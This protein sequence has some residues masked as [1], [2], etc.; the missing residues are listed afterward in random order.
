MQLAGEEEAI[1]RRYVALVAL[2]ASPVLSRPGFAHCDTTRGPV[3]TAAGAALEA[4]DPNLVLHWV[5]PD[6]EAAVKRAFQQTL[7][8]RAL[9]PEAKALADRYFF[10]TPR[11]SRPLEPPRA[12]GPVTSPEGA[13]SSLPMCLSPTG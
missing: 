2:L 8:V 6:D 1:M 11:G 9:G 10:E 7:Q 5:R 13:P 12:S 4:G 3:V